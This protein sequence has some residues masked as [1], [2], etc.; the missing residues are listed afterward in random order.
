MDY[1]NSDLDEQVTISLPIKDWAEIV[2]AI[3][4]SPLELSTKERLNGVIFRSTESTARAL[5]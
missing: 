5:S 2:A 3:G 1:P 4:L